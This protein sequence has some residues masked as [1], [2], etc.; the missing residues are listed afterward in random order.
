MVRQSAAAISSWYSAALI[1]IETVTG[2]IVRGAVNR[3][4]EKPSRSHAAESTAYEFRAAWIHRQLTCITGNIS[5]YAG[6]KSGVDQDIPLP[7][8]VLAHRIRNLVG[9]PVH[10]R[11][12][13][14]NAVGLLCSLEFYEISFLDAQVFSNYLPVRT[15]ERDLR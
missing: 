2:H 11:D 7:R 14:D 8:A 6:K 3:L 5:V 15:V 9:L 12:I 13:C 10:F 4:E 1:G